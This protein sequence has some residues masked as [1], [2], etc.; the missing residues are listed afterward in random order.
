MF[1]ISHAF[2]HTLFLSLSLP[3]ANAER[4]RPNCLVYGKNQAPVR[5]RC[6]SK[7]L[8]S[9]HASVMD[10]DSRERHPPIDIST[11][12]K[13]RKGALRWVLRYH[14]QERLISG[15]SNAMNGKEIPSSPITNQRQSSSR[16]VVIGLISIYQNIRSRYG[17]CP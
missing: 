14:G 4:G 5:D 6:R 9:H 10:D 13:E 7:C 16:S 3:S 1:F 8:A 12:R 15:S 2:S 17:P 11:H